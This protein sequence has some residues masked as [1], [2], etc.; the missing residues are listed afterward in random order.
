[1]TP[2]AGA[3]I[4]GPGRIEARL[5]TA[6]IHASKI[7]PEQ[8]QYAKETRHRRWVTPPDGTAALSSSESIPRTIVPKD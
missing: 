5:S 2:S 8:Q 1:M 6:N 7:I 3:S 4:I